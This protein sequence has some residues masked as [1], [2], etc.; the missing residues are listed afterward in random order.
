MD[1]SGEVVLLHGIIDCAH[2]TI[3]APS[4]RL[5]RHQED[6]GD[7]GVIDIIRTISSHHM[8]D[9]EYRQSEYSKFWQDAHTRNSLIIQVNPHGLEMWRT[10][11]DRIIEKQAHLTNRRN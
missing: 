2:K 1:I 7:L 3:I 9:S 4:L 5:D 11:S 6:K 8:V 10:I